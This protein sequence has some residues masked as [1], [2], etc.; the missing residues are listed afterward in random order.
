MLLADVNVAS[1]CAFKYLRFIRRGRT[2]CIIHLQSLSNMQ[3]HHVLCI[4]ILFV[5]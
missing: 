1:S 4:V 3:R 5:I 2:L